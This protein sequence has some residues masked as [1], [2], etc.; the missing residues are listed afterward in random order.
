MSNANLERG[1][2]QT[3]IILRC[4][5][6]NDSAM[7]QAPEI[8]HPDT[9]VRSTADKYINAICAKS[10]V[11]HLLIMSNQLRLCRER[12]NIP[13]RTCCI[14]AGSDDEAGRN[15]IPIERGQRGSVFRRF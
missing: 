6:V 4:W 5:L 8:K 9:T 13:Y 1:V 7:L 3:F 14:N 10:D 11:E 12:W 15:R 2:L